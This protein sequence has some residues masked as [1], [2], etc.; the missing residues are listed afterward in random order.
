MTVDGLNSAWENYF[1]RRAAAR[2][3]LAD[4]VEEEGSELWEAANILLIITNYD[5]INRQ[6]IP[7]RGGGGATE[8]E[9]RGRISTTAKWRATRIR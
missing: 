2:R 9:R 8:I 1:R 6:K 5:V 7:G 4:G 3:R